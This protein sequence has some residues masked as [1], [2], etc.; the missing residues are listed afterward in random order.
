MPPVPWESYLVTIELSFAKWDSK[1]YGG[2]LLTLGTFIFGKV[3]AV[4]IKF[5]MKTFGTNTQL[6]VVRVL[7]YVTIRMDLDPYLDNEQMRSVFKFYV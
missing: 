2:D 1:K 5:Y 6:Q 3:K 4:P 7:V